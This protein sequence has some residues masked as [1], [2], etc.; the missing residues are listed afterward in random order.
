[1]KTFLRSLALFLVAGLGGGAIALAVDDDGGGQ[2]TTVVRTVQAPQPAADPSTPADDLSAAEIYRRD[3]PGVVVI[4]ATTVST[5]ENPLDP[6]GSPQEQRGQSLGSGFVID[7]QGHI[8][9][10]AHVVLDAQ[11]VEVGFS[12]GATYEAEVVGA[13]RATDIAVLKVDVPADALR[14]LP[15]GS[16]RDVQVGDPVVAIGNPL[17]TE[18]TLTAG[19]VSAVSREIESLEQGVQIYGVIQTDASINH[20]NSG[21]PLIDADGRVIGVNSQILSENNGNVGIGF[22]VPVDTARRVAEEIVDTGRA[23]HT[24][25]GIEGTELTAEIAEQ[26]DL[27]ESGVLVGRV[28]EG[29]PAE[30][31]GLRGGDEQAT[32]DGQTLTLG[33][34]VITRIDGREVRTFSDLA[35]TIAEHQAGD[36]IQLTIVRDG[37]TRTVSVTL[38][39]RTSG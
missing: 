9:T 39:E 33:G 4:T 1:M 24:W 23:S 11:Q 3:A 18:R 32:V 15:L 22:A 29:S 14:P 7:R 26:R 10:N 31:A 8:I 13:D 21:G 16:A 27:P 17:G 5:Q 20:G 6:F 12:N 34:D 2:S 28:V 25:L 30:R 38:A 19:I 35:Q 36:R 37:E